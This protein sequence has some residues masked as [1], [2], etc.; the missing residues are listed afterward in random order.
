MRSTEIIQPDQSWRLLLGGSIIVPAGEVVGMVVEAVEGGDEGDI[1]EVVL[2]DEMVRP[3]VVEVVVDWGEEV[4]AGI[5]DR[6]GI[7]GAHERGVA[8]NLPCIRGSRAALRRFLLCRSSLMS[9]KN[10]EHLVLRAIQNHRA[11]Q[12]PLFSCLSLLLGTPPIMRVLT[13]QHAWRP[14]A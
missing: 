3:T 1:K 14:L 12:G 8:V 4:V 10:I 9:S 13:A 11:S 5:A 6:R 7:C 2:W